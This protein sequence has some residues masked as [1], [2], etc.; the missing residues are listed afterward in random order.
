MP[1]AS[2]APRRTGSDWDGIDI[3]LKRSTDGGTTWSESRVLAAGASR[4]VT[5][6][7]PVLITDGDTVH[8][9]FCREYA[10]AQ[11]G[12]GVFH[13]RSGNDALTWSE[14]RDISACTHPENYTRNVLACGPGH[15]IVYSNGTLLCPVWMTRVSPGEPHSS[16][17]SQSH[18][19]SDIA[20][21]YS[22]DQ[23]GTWQIG[24]VI[25]SSPDI[26]NMSECSAAELSDGR[27]MLNIR[28]E[29]SK[30]RRALAISP[31]G[32]TNWTA[33]AL[34]GALVDPICCGSLLRYD[35]STLLFC[36]AANEYRRENLTLRLSFDDGRTWPQAIVIDPGA[37]Q[38]ADIAVLD[39]SVYV[40]YEKDSDILLAKIERE[41]IDLCKST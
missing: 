17:G 27:V 15:G 36:N 9:L 22:N 6:N 1:A 20:T 16:P 5:M 40:L 21:L 31:D 12:G 24:E 8:L 33:P 11:R 13:M 38:Y 29:S 14:P 10:V 34:D 26:P 18:R 30:K 3:V 32:Y 23:G 39:G 25:H 28:N 19:P 4:G 41:A 35:G 37:A 7:N 2:T